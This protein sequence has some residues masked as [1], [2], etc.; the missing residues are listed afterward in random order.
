MAAGKPLTREES[1]KFAEYTGN[2]RESEFKR[3]VSTYKAE[4]DN[5]RQ[6]TDAINP[7]VPELQAQ[8]IHP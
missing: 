1:V 3:G 8:G 2:I 6:L 4:A 7:F 5:A